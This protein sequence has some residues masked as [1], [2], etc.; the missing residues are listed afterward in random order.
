MI[1]T[2]ETFLVLFPLLIPVWEQR[3]LLPDDLFPTPYPIHMSGAD[4]H[5]Q[6]QGLG[7]VDAELRCILAQHLRQSGEPAAQEV[8]RSQLHTEK[9]PLVLATILQQFLF[10]PLE[11]PPAAAELARLRTHGA[12]YAGV[13][14]RIQALLDSG[15]PWA[16]HYHAPLAVW[17]F[18]ADLTLVRLSG[19]VVG[20]YIRLLEQALGP[21]GLWVAGYCEDYYGYLPSAR[22]HREG[23]YEARDFITGFGYLDAGCEAAVLA[24]AKALARQVGRVLPD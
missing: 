18:G 2:I 14:D 6:R 21:L 7:V 19:E 23:G 15:K 3:P 1:P 24:Q 16:T 4:I 8:L 11:P 9:D 22:V 10:M 20:D 17:Q 12:Y 13:A 5:M